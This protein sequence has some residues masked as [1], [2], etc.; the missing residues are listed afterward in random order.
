MSTTCILD[1]SPLLDTWFA[2]I[3]SWSFYFLTVPFKEKKISYI[4]EIQFIIFFC[5]GVMGKKS[6]P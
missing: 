3:V 2:N 4:D 6:F 5:Y 1:T